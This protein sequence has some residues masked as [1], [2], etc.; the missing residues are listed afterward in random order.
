MNAEGGASQ[1]FRKT[2]SVPGSEGSGEGARLSGNEAREKIGPRETE[3]QR[4]GKSEIRKITTDTK[5]AWETQGKG[6]N[7]RKEGLLSKQ[8][9]HR[10]GRERIKEG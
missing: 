3:N 1:K 8:G 9:N 5:A 2:R 7:L 10:A 6:C 4:L